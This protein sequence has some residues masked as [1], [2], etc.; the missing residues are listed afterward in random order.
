MISVTDLPDTEALTGAEVSRRRRA[1]GMTQGQLAAALGITQVT[2]ARWE[3]DARAI[4]SPRV[5][6]LALRWLEQNASTA[7]SSVEEGTA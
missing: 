1:L 7:A 3:T 2:V 4:Q 6:D 5:L